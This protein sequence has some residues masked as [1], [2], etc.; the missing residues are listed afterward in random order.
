MAN[1]QW[2]AKMFPNRPPKNDIV[3]FIR[4]EY[5]NEVKHLRDEDAVSFYD[6]ITKHKQQQRRA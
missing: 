5:G 2:F 4:T 1:F 6:H 3:R